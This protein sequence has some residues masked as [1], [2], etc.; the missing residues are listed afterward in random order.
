MGHPAAG[1][2]TLIETLKKEGTFSLLGYGRSTV[3]PH[4]A[5][6]VPSIYDTE[7]YGRVIFYDFAGD[8]EYYSSHAAI[9]ENIDTSEGV[10]LY[11]VVCDL[12]NDNGL[13]DQK[14]WL[15]ALISFI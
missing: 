12:S 2:S 4:T 1:K 9:L 15:L 14:I 13:L 11:L 3:L 5:G 7:K 6:I 10:N 8:R